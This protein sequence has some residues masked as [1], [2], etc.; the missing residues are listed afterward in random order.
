[1]EQTNSFG[2]WLQARLDA[3]NMSQADLAHEMDVARTMVNRYT[4]G[5][6][7]P[8]PETCRKLATGLRMDTVDVLIAAGWVPAITD[9]RQRLV[10]LIRYLPDSKVENARLYLQFLGQQRE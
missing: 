9:A 5:H 4:Q 6:L 2:T 1:M 7:V 10:E 3:L 8:P